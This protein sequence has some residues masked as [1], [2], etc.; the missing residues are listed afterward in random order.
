[1]E[2]I[3]SPEPQKDANGGNWTPKKKN[4]PNLRDQNG[5]ESLVELTILNVQRDLFHVEVLHS[6]ATFIILN[7]L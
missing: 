5:N 3:F 6:V 4:V 1:M 2:Q 7:L